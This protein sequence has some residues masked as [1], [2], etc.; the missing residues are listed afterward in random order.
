M[1][2]TSQKGL[3]KIY[4][5]YFEDSSGIVTVAEHPR[6]FDLTLPKDLISFYLFL[7]KLHEQARAFAA[8]LQNWQP[9]EESHLKKFH[10]RS[11]DRDKSRKRAR[12]GADSGESDIVGGNGGG[13]DDIACLNDIE[14]QDWS[15]NLQSWKQD[16]ASD[17]EV[18]KRIAGEEH[19]LRFETL[20]QH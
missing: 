13:L 16:A 1:G 17:R 9:P 15:S 5:S 10:W 18:A 4:S 3:V 8:E 19:E 2:V 6:T 7:C 11:P 14:D 20:V 12:F